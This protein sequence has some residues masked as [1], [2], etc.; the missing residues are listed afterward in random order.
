[1]SETESSPASAAAARTAAN[2]S[3]P[4]CGAS[5]TLRAL[6]QSVMVSCPSC[7][8]QLDVSRPD[9]QII[10]KYREKAS[11][12]RIPL[13]K[14][15]VLRR[16]MF[17]VV[18]AMQRSVDG[19]SWHEYLLFNPYTGFRWLVSDSG[20]WSLGRTVRG[21]VTV[22]ADDSVEF[23]GRR[24]KKFQQGRPVVDWVI[25]EFYWRVA[26]GD[27]V[28]SSDY[29]SPPFMLSRESSADEN[30]WTQLEYIEPVE[31][32]VA[33]GASK[34]IQSGVAPNQPNPVA[35]S[36]AQIK[37]VAIAALALAVL[38]QAFTVSYSRSRDVPVGRYSFFDPKPEQV[39]GPF[40]F[41][42]PFSLNELMASAPLR[43]SWAELDCT[44]VNVTTGKSYE[45]TNAFSY[46]YGTDSD[47]AWSEG[48]T[49]HVS[50]I[51]RIPAGTYNLVVDGASGDE[52]G[53]RIRDNVDLVMRHDVAP[54]QNFW[55]AVLAILLC[56]L[57]LAFRFFSFEKERWA[58][59]DFNPYSWGSE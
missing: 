38:I 9:I 11:G 10:R 25:G 4:S 53:Q 23:E 14:R 40:T 3:C 58:D 29:I 49:Q 19:Y 48:E 52:S 36:T 57:Y 28:S 17:E 46:Y 22:S 1:M 18:G 32:Q 55:I 33:F 27:R 37:R 15:G 44:L 24:Y 56:P 35:G 31:I 6:G 13:G 51:S 30:I 41:D 39:F 2:V 47:G 43:N 45:F 54:W 5:I 50:A 21:D 16:Q 42:A 26:V 8:T 20:H 12:L 59:S 7:A 34:P